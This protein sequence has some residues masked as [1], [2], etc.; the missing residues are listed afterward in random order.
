VKLLKINKLNKGDTED[1]EIKKS[2]ASP[3]R[4]SSA[5]QQL[6]VLSSEEKLKRFEKLG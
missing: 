5:E 4:E 3:S 1:S 2:S 6:Q